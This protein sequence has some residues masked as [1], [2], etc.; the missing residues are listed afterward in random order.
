MGRAIQSHLIHSS[1]LATLLARLKKAPPP[2]ESGVTWITA[3]AEKNWATPLMAVKKLIASINEQQH[4]QTQP[5]T[6]GTTVSPTTSKAEF[7]AGPPIR[8]YRNLK[9]ISEWADCLSE[10]DRGFI[11][12]KIK[13]R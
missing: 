5:T 10:L 8:S 1:S 4:L 13:R 6:V 9:H 11:R 7:G 12:K 2:T 3:L